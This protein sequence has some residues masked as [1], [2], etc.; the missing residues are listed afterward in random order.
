[1]GKIYQLLDN[2]P[3]AIKYFGLAKN[4]Y[5]SQDKSAV[6]RCQKYLNDLKPQRLFHLHGGIGSPPC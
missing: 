1:M 5:Q 3:E 4:I 2:K 6:K